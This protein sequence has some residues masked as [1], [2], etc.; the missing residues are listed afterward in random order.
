MCINSVIS[1]ESLFSLSSTDFAGY[2]GED[3]H[4]IEV[5]HST[6]ITP[7]IPGKIDVKLKRV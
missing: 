2:R 7:S 6:N 1:V 4:F 3:G 5:E